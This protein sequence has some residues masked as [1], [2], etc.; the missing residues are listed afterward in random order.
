MIISLAN[1]MADGWIF[2][3]DKFMSVLENHQAFDSLRNLFGWLRS[4]FHSC[5]DSL[6]PCIFY[7]SIFPLNHRIRRRR[8]VRRWI[9]EGYSK[10]T[11]EMTAEEQG[12]KSFYKLCMLNMIQVPGSSSLSYLTRMPSCQVNGF[13]REYIISRSMEE[14]LVFA[15]EGHHSVNS[16]HTGRHLTIGRTWD[17]DKNMYQ[18]IDFSRLRSLT[19]F[20]KWES[21]FISDNMKTV[22]VL[23]LE[24][25]LSVTDGDLRQMVKVLPLLKFLSLRGCKEITR[26]PYSF[27]SLRQLQTLD[28]KHTSIDVL[29]ICITKLH[30]LQ[31]I[32]AG[33]TVLLDDDTVI[34]VESLATPSAPEPTPDASMSSSTNRPQAATLVSRPHLPE[35]RPRDRKRP[36]RC[37]NGVVAPRGIGRMMTLHNISVIDISAA[38]G[39]AIL[40][41]LKNLTQMRKLGVSGV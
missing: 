16:Q 23:D 34:T 5:P 39:R 11:K 10:D 21:F 1:F 37:R 40:E 9:T 3:S 19:V 25:A 31:H 12:E 13:I 17:R 35:L 30:Q 33:T 22:R 24:D 7:L 18:S 41:E 14:N 4:D 27:G 15:L 32:R 28:I 20:G 38:S 36:S 6:K 29:P 8:L 2:P 26:L